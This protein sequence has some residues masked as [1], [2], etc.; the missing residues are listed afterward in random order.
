MKK[1]NCTTPTAGSGLKTLDPEIQ[2]TGHV[3]GVSSISSR[4][5]ARIFSL[6]GLD[7]IA[8]V[9]RREQ[10]LG[11]RLTLGLKGDH[12]NHNHCEWQPHG[13]AGT[14]YT[15]TTMATKPV[16]KRRKGHHFPG[17]DETALNGTTFERRGIVF[18]ILGRGVEWSIAA[19]MIITREGED[20]MWFRWGIGIRMVMSIRRGIGMMLFMGPID[21]AVIVV[22][23][24]VG[25]SNSEEWYCQTQLGWKASQV[26]VLGP[27]GA[28][29]TGFAWRMVGS[30]ADLS[31]ILL[32][33]P[34]GVCF[35]VE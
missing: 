26:K 19:A 31:V 16:R 12:H 28:D 7:L 27:S 32:H 13:Q 21:I 1:W 33:F 34:Q 3:D 6:E 11:L 4:T 29:W 24:V 15:G 10:G 30:W 35:M 5:R 9:P 18:R 20:D 17:R 25:D 22:T 8:P 2:P 23:V 14:M